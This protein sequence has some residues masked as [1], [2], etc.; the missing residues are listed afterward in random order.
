MLMFTMGDLIGG[1]ASCGISWA[2][3]I[4]MW[5]IA[6]AAKWWVPGIKVSSGHS[7]GAAGMRKAEA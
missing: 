2:I 6:Y 5:I 7:S 4:V 3:L 1:W